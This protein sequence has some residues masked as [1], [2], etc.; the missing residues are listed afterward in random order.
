MSNPEEDNSRGKD[1]GPL[2]H[3][4]ISPPLPSG[5]LNELVSS[6]LQDKEYSF[7]ETSPTP[8]PTVN[9]PVNLDLGWEPGEFLA[10][11][12]GASNVGQTIWRIVLLGLDAPQTTIGLELY[13]DIIIG[14]S[15]TDGEPD[16][17]LTDYGPGGADE[18]GISRQHALMHPTSDELLLIDL[19]S[20]NGT[21]LNGSRLLSTEPQALEDKDVIMFGSLQFQIRIVGSSG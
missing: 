19:G 3:E 9:W 10:R 16:L 13:A 5:E 14:R 11:P 4:D 20:T 21:R 2:S 8:H 17:D 12:T 6:I 15:G 1:T 18:F 7:K